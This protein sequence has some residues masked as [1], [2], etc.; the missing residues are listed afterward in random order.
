MMCGEAL[1][2]KAF[3][4]PVRGAPAARPPRVEDEADGG[5]VQKA[6]NCY[7]CKYFMI[8]HR[9]G[10]AR[11]CTMFGFKSDEMPSYV[12]YNVS[13]IHCMKFEDKDGADTSDES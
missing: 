11:A 6:P 12:L 2:N 7:K 3:S 13:G 4:P 10:K 9:A 1:S 8:T 5:A